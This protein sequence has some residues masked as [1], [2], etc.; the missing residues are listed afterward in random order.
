LQELEDSLLAEVFACQEVTNKLQNYIDDEHDLFKKND[1]PKQESVNIH[2]SCVVKDGI[3][4][5]QDL[6]SLEL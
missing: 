2:D 6:P 5:E 4:T 3:K 1:E